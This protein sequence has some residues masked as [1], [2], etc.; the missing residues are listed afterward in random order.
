MITQQQDYHNSPLSCP[1]GILSR[2]GRGNISPL[3]GEMIRSTKEGAANGFTLIELL[4]VVLIIGILAAVALPQYQ[5]AVE[6]S[7]AAEAITLM[8]SIQ[9]A[10]DVWKLSHSESHELVGCEDEENGICGQ[11]DIDVESVLTC[12]QSD[13]DRCRSKY[14]AYDAYCG[15]NDYCYIQAD[16]YKDGNWDDEEEQFYL[17]LRR[18]NETGAWTKECVSN[19]DY[20]YAAS[21][22]AS[23]LAQ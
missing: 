16:R 15:N 13:G 22:C 11:L 6:K 3:A 14:F 20:P 2:K 7:R 19:D 21:I 23:F 5:K 18:D 8:S 17:E 9:K 1:T 4:V 12:D 10:V